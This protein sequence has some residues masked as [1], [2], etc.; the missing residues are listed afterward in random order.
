MAV[1]QNEGFIRENPIQ[2]DDSGVPPFMETPISDI[3][4]LPAGPQWPR[5]APPDPCYTNEGENL[6]P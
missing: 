5:L 3:D 1:P 4:P 2:M 6:L